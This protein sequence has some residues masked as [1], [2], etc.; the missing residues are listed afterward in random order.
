MK[1]E[2]LLYFIDLMQTG[3]LSQTAE[4]FF[5][6]HQ[7]ISKAIKNLEDELNVKL[8]ITNNQGATLT[9]A[10]NI[11]V[12][13]AQEISTSVNNL[14]EELS[15]YLLQTASP[16]N[17]IVFCTSPYLTDNL[18]LA[19]VNDY[20]KRIPN[21]TFELISLPFSNMISQIDSPNAVF[22]IPTIESA[23]REQQFAMDLERYGL[24]FFVL[25]ERSLYACTHV[26]SAWAK[27]DFI[28][29]DMLKTMPLII[30]SNVSLNTNFNRNPRNQ[31]VNSISAQKSLIKMDK[32]IGVFT[33]TEFD[34]YFRNEKQYVLIPVEMVPVQY[35]C[36]RQK[37]SEMPEH[38]RAFLEE[39]KHCF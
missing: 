29:E 16:R 7:V 31:L 34:Y 3:S 18:I 12:R 14:K 15:P 36:I 1:T 37:S 9:E 5:T 28:T 23:T 25:A 17:K 32:G 20:E 35:I 27:C 13:Y 39:L 22:V 11:L 21:I 24:E 8:I 19:F 10:G 33:K 26:K 30:S 6:S 2:S 38:I 4:H